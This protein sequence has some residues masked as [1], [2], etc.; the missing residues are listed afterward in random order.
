MAA[1]SRLTFLDIFYQ[2]AQKRPGEDRRSNLSAALATASFY[3]AEGFVSPNG[4]EEPRLDT[5][6]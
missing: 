1:S 3:P 6:D 5:N 4:G 2:S